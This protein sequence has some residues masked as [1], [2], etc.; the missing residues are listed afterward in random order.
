METIPDKNKPEW[1][2]LLTDKIN[3]KIENFVLQMQ[4]DQ[5]KRAIKSSKISLEE[6]VDKIYNL[7]CKYS[8]AVKNDMKSIF[9]L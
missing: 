5:T 3:V 1:R 6:G 7:C 8:L 4:I 9:N 2:Y